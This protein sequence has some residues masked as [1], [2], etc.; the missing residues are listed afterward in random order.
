MTGTSKTTLSESPAATPCLWY[1]RVSLLASILLAIAPLAINLPSPLLFP[2][3][4]GGVYLCILWPCQVLYLWIL[5]RLRAKPQKEALAAAVGTGVAVI[6][7][8]LL[9]AYQSR[10][11]Q[12]EYTWP[13]RYFGLL[14]LTQIALVWS[15]IKTYYALSR[16]PE[17]GQVLVKWMVLAWVYCFLAAVLLCGIYFAYLD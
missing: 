2:G 5:W 4:L 15:A 7:L 3:Q 1:V 12:A 11:V 16:Q 14:L 9:C 6:T 8:T 10:D 13:V 17:D